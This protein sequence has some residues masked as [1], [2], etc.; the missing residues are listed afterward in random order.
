M[1]NFKLHNVTED[2]IR[3]TFEIEFPFKEIA[4]TLD[5]A[6]EKTVDKNKFNELF[7]NKNL[8]KKDKKLVTFQPLNVKWRP[9]GESRLGWVFRS[10][11][12]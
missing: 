2:G 11:R 1:V 7:V 10:C 9:F 5:I 4:Q 12:S 8:D 3:F 6:I